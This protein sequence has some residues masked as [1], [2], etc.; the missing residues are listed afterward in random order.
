MKAIGGTRAQMLSLYLSGV[1]VMAC[2][3]FS[4]PCRGGRGRSRFLGRHAR[5]LWRSTGSGVPRLESGRM[6]QSSSPARAAPGGAV[7]DLCRVRLTVREAISSY[8]ISAS[9]GKGL[10]D[11]LL[12]RW[13]GLPRPLALILR[14]TFRRKGR[15]V[16]TEIALVVAGVVFHHGD[17]LRRIVLAHHR[18]FEQIGWLQSSDRL[19]APRSQ[20]GSSGDHC[21]AA[22]VEHVEM[23]LSEGST[24]VPG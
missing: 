6:Q 8:G 18:F 22:N 9:Y 3:P 19:S 1:L 13:R 23:Q 7:A 2:W 20:R 14:N 17:E 16:L 10:S 4:L 21:R 15:V 5:R 11:R 24:A 12:A